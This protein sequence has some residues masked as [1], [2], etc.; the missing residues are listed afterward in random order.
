[1]LSNQDLE[2]ILEAI[3]EAHRRA[4][5]SLQMIELHDGDDVKIVYDNR[6]EEGI[7]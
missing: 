4:G 7:Q 1:M 5:R 3:E 2:K 6:E